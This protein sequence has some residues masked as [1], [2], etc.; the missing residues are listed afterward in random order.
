[1]PCAYLE[2]SKGY[3][4]TQN[5]RRYGDIWR[6]AEIIHKHPNTIRRMVKAGYLARPSIDT[7]LRGK[8]WDLDNL[9]IQAGE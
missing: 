1:M 2:N 7:G 3:E 6:V 9:F 5:G 4:F 8:L